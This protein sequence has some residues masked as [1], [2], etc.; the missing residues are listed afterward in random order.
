MDHAVGKS[1][2]GGMPKSPGCNTGSRMGRCVATLDAKPVDRL[3]AY[4]PAIACQVASQI[5]GRPAHSG[6]GSLHFAE[7]NAW[8]DGDAAHADFE[9]QL[10]ADLV[11]IHRELDLDVL[12]M[13]WR[14]NT[15]PAAR[16]DRHTFR[17]GPEN[18]PHAIWQYQPES[19]D[20]G[21][22]A[23]VPSPL[24]PTSRL[25]NEIA[26]LE[27]ALEDAAGS[28]HARISA[29]RDLWQRFGGEFFVIGA[30]GG[31]GT[32]LEPES[33]ELLLDEPDLMR[34]KFDLQGQ[35]AVAVARALMEAGC[36]PVLL[37]G[38][39][40]AGAHGPFFSPQ[41]FRELLLPAYSR[42]IAA[43]TQI[44]GHYVFRSDGNLWLFA[45]MLFCDAAC[46]GFG[47]ADRDAGMTVRALREQF[48]RLVI[49]GNISSSLLMQ[50]S[51]QAVRQQ[52]ADIL[53]EAERTGCFQGCSNAI[54]HGTPPENVVAMFA[55]R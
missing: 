37:G 13:P 25:R 44:G 6:T 40:L 32:D 33:L 51:A 5:L 3:P 24:D 14:M 45:D 22:V 16:I 47:E 2:G 38:G 4:L 39:D 36:P 42:T 35:L 28:A 52:A 15:R 53:T 29:V 50:G 21:V 27:H 55:V 31:I 26:R 49:W 18:G 23:S 48:P 46:P 41:V 20:F 43:I 12:R 1:Q 10:I 30:G 54:V 19:G 9:E 17:F 34:A 8:A 11:A 7:V